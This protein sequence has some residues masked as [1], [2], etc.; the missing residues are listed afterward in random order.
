MHINIMLNHIANSVQ[1]RHLFTTIA[2]RFLVGHKVWL[3]KL[4]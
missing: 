4:S 1:A 2:P 3:K